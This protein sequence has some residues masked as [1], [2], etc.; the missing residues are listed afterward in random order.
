[1]TDFQKLMRVERIK[2]V[3]DAAKVLA[4]SFGA[5]ESSFLEADSKLNEIKDELAKKVSGGVSANN[6]S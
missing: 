2:K 5:L 6:P 4:I 3:Y 1:M